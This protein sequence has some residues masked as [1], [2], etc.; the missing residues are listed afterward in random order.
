MIISIS[1]KIW[2]RGPENHSNTQ[3]QG[4]IESEMAPK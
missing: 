2:F 1:L 3:I 4:F